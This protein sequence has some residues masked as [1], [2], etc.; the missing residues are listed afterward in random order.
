[1][2][3]IFFALSLFFP[4]GAMEE[5]CSN[6]SLTDRLLTLLE[7][8]TTTPE[9]VEELIVLGADVHAVTD[10]GRT[11]LF[12]AAYEGNIA[13]CQ[14][15]LKK[16]LAVNAQVLRGEF[17]GCTPLMA[18]AHNN[19]CHLMKVLI[20]HGAQGHLINSIGNT[21]L[22]V[23]VH[24]GQAEACRLLLTTPTLNV[25]KNRINKDG[26]TALT[27]AIIRD[28]REEARTWLNRKN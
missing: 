18:A 21:A 9:E 14:I 1:M 17:K 19:N 22:L 12:I 10:D 28:A 5:L 15:L 11:A 2:K 25:D 24:E 27:K 23:A 3:K 16:N 8:S 20:E 6:H 4:L 26:S 13:V 7:N